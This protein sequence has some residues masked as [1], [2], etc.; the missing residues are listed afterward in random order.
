LYSLQFGAGREQLTGFSAADRLIDLA[1]RIHSF[2]D[3][4]AIMGN[5]DLVISCD[6][7]PVHLAGALGARVWTALPQGPDWRWMLDREETPWYPTMRLWRQRSL[8]DWNEL[9]GRIAD[10]LSCLVRDRC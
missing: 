8:G 9:F 5:L 7:A 4:A 10:Q 2:Q 3:T 1:D 6:S